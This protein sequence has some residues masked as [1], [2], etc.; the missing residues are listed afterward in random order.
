MKPITTPETLPAWENGLTKTGPPRRSSRGGFSLLEVI[1]A[2]ALL[3]ASGVLLFQLASI[4]R[5]H[6][7]SI[8]QMSE[9]QLIAQSY[10]DEIL[11]GLRPVTRVEG[12]SVAGHPDW[13]W[14]CELDSV[15]GYT[16]VVSL[17]LTVRQAVEDSLDEEAIGRARSF[18][19]V[20][21]IADPGGLD[22]NQTDFDEQTAE[23]ATSDNAAD[24][25]GLEGQL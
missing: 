17:T 15:D 3:A 6:A 4:G 14:N 23:E 21:W 19:L 8:E 7:E 11:C 24:P 10:L 18:T 9:A 22:D 13:V 12:E 1:V 2:T 5:R 20:Q 25:N 16:G